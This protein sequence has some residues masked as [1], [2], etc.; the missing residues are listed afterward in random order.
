M[1]LSFAAKLRKTT[2]RDRFGGDFWINQKAIDS[3][4]PELQQY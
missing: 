1:T 2:H 4:A 3:L